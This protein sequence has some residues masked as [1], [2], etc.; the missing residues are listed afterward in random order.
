MRVYLQFLQAPKGENWSLRLV[1]TGRS[2]FACIISTESE[3]LESQSASTTSPG[4]KGPQFQLH[5]CHLLP[6]PTPPPPHTH[7]LFP[8]M[9]L[10]P[11][12][13]IPRRIF[14]VLCVYKTEQAEA[15]GS[16]HEGRV[17]EQ[18]KTIVCITTT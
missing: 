14:T 9:T 7:T 10:L 16:K 3:M 8:H 12:G 13:I 17:F 2:S 6:S 1:K 5:V 4:S 15:L 11:R 18:L